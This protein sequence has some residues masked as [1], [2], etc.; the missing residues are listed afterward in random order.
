MNR[1]AFERHN[2][3]TNNNFLNFLSAASEESSDEE[4]GE[5]E[6]ETQKEKQQQKA[7]PF[8]PPPAT[9]QPNVEEPVTS[10]E[11]IRDVMKKK[12]R[13]AWA[14]KTP[15]NDVSQSA[16]SVPF[17]QQ[18]LPHPPPQRPTIRS[19]AFS[20]LKSTEDLKVSFFARKIAALLRRFVISRGWSL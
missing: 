15:N 18:H 1:V 9:S 12:K 19:K 5:E 10:R 17:K 16:P 13:V 3:P 7:T 11:P 4:E 6:E 2:A 20:S 14:D 8:P